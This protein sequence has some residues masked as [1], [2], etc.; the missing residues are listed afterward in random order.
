MNGYF[1]GKVKAA[2]GIFG[3]VVITVLGIAV[4][5]SLDSGTQYLPLVAKTKATTRIPASPKVTLTHT[6]APSLTASSTAFSDPQPSATPNP[7]TPE[8][9]IGAVFTPYPSAPLCSDD[10][11]NVHIFHTLWDSVRGCHYDHEHGTSPF[12]ESV[13]AVFFEFDIF[14]LLCG[15]EV[16][17]CNPS[18]PMENTHK[19]GGMKWQVD[20]PIAQGCTLGFENAVTGVDNA[21][22]EYHAFGDYAVEFETRV[23]STL[24]MGRLCRPGQ[25]PG[26]IFTIQHQDYGQRVGQYQGDVLQYPDTP[27]PAYA[28]GL[29][30]YFTVDRYGDCVG[31][32]P[33]LA[34]VR[35]NNY[36]ANSI[37]T[38]KGGH[39]EGSTLFNL[40]FRVR[41]NYQLLEWHTTA[42]PFIFGWVCG[43]TAYDALGCRYNNSTSTVHE[44]SG[45]IP[46]AWDNAEGID[47]DP[48][49]GR[50][51][52]EGYTTRYGLVNPNCNGPSDECFPLKLVRAFTGLY[53]AELS[54]SKVTNPNPVDTP[55][56]DL[57][58]CA[59]G[60][61]CTETSTGAIPSGWIGPSN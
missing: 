60:I 21:V 9:T 25:D 49:I 16:G 24:F 8:P 19:H 43:E 26:Y 32:R 47:T 5:Q 17:H 48:E 12:T 37:W 13:S 50:V 61:V 18:S 53:G 23:H 58:F 54:A 39:A 1:N 35:N 59:G 36:N 57:Y 7:F 34:F 6:P 20:V 28:A 41:D 55:E 56:R 14:A 11:H 33:S 51:T 44:I 45:I 38:S 4:G 30:P 22:I 46:Q 31:C 15:V 52:F 3:A 10:M 40:L 27:L 2:L 42:Y 29:G